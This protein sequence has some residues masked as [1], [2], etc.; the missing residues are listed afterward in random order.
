MAEELTRRAREVHRFLADNAGRF[1]HPPTL[2]ELARAMGMRSRGSLHK[3]VQALVDA[4]LLEPL[5]GRRRGLRMAEPHSLGDG[6]PFL[7]YVAAGRP[8]EAL[9][10]PGSV[11]VPAALRPSGACY[12]LQVRG[13]SMIGEGIL[14]G[15]RVVV[16]AREH[17]RD[18]ELVVALVDGAEATLKR[19]A[20]R[21]GQVVLHP[22]NPALAPM[23]YEASR[24]QVRG[25]VRGLLRAY[26]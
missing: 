12:V 20:R 1:P 6:V 4:G 19:I 3:H 23:A 16:E 17:A 9:E 13:D 2:D 7:G 22:S 18:G 8:I 24:V 5:D 11:D 25:V 21:G 15:D 14:D 26:C 10:N